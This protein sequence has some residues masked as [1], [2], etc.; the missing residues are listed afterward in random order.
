VLLCIVLLA[1]HAAGVIGVYANVARRRQAAR[2]QRVLTNL[3]RLGDALAEYASDFDKELSASRPALEMP[4]GL[5]DD[6]PGETFTGPDGGATSRP[7]DSWEEI[8]GSRRSADLTDVPADA[9]EPVEPPPPAPTSA[10]AP[11]PVTLA[12]RSRTLGILQ[13]MPLSEAPWWICAYAGGGVLGIGAVTVY[14][15]IL[16]GRGARRTS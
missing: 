2:T 8:F 5:F 16:A 1:L 15:W 14:L 9:G 11:R 10:P 7:A 3:R 13:V 4:G 12:K 6:P